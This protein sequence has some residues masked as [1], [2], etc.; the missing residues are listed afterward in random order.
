MSPS[1]DRA[2]ANCSIMAHLLLS[3]GRSTRDSKFRFRS[4]ILWE[5]ILAHDS[6]QGLKLYAL[7]LFLTEVFRWTNGPSK[8]TS[9]YLVCYTSK[10]ALVPFVAWR[11]IPSFI[12]WAGIFM[13]SIHIG[14]FVMQILF[15]LSVWIMIANF[16]RKILSL[17]DQCG[18]LGSFKPQILFF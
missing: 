13:L 5:K 4:L 9:S 1:F 8:N 18:S 2:F 15:R 14:W 6:N 11:W 3:G 12:T 10:P 17:V 7:V 16:K